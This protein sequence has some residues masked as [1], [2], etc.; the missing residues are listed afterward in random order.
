MVEQQ[1]SRYSIQE[2]ESS[3][4]TSPVVGVSSVPLHKSV[5]QAVTGESIQ[6]P[7]RLLVSTCNYADVALGFPELSVGS[8][9]VLLILVYTKFHDT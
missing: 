9:I 2:V 6:S 7:N 8:S 5:I 3:A 4:M 1:G